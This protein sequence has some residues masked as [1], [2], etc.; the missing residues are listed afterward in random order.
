MSGEQF[1]LQLHGESA[2]SYAA[3]SPGEG[4]AP[5]YGDPKGGESWVAAPRDGA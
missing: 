4:V 1:H 2:V 5:K 3:L